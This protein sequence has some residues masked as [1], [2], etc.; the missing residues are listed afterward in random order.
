VADL[1]ARGVQASLRACRSEVC[2]TVCHPYKR[3]GEW[4]STASHVS[5]KKPTQI[6]KCHLPQKHGRFQ[7][8]FYPELGEK[9]FKTVRRV[10]LYVQMNHAKPSKM[11]HVDELQ[12]FHLEAAIISWDCF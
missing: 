9:N 12:M 4:L 1:P 2:G 3:H 8:L 11:I 6:C 10:Q 5:W 7:I